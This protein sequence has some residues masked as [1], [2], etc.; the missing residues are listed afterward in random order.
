LHLQAQSALLMQQFLVFHFMF[1]MNAAEMATHRILFVEA[2]H[3]LHFMTRQCPNPQA[4]SST[5]GI[6]HFAIQCPAPRRCT[7]NDQSGA[8]KFHSLFH[9]HLYHETQ[10]SID[11]R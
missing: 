10:P 5:S 8:A 4:A 3:S 11:M 1:S 6:E 9:Q 2:E 7:Q